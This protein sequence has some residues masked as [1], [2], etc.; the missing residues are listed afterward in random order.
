MKIEL[1]T[2]GMIVFDNGEEIVQ[3]F[4]ASVKFVR[5][6]RTKHDP[7]SKVKHDD[8]LVEVGGDMWI[9]FNAKTR[10]D[11]NQIR[12]QVNEILDTFTANGT[13]GMHYA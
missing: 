6:S 3:T 8:W 5:I 7:K 9:E 10:E 12:G 1:L 4:P 11:A 2:N 13:N